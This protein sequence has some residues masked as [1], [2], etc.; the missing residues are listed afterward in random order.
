VADDID[1]ASGNVVYSNRKVATAANVFS[2]AHLIGYSLRSKNANFA[3][4]RESLNSVETTRK[5]PKKFLN[6]RQLGVCALF[7]AQN[8]LTQT[9]CALS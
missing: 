6:F 2:S 4:A 7:P 3:M 8:S 9:G 1:I 5:K